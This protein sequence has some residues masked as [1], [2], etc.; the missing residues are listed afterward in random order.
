MTAR[1]SAIRAQQE[2]YRHR[3]SQICKQPTPALQKR[4][5]EVLGASLR[6]L[7]VTSATMDVHGHAAR[8]WLGMRLQLACGSPADAASALHP[9]SYLCSAPKLQLPG[10]AA[11]HRR[12]KLQQDCAR[13]PQRTKRSPAMPATD[14]PHTGQ[15]TCQGIPFRTC[16]L[17]TSPSP[18]DRTRSRMPSSA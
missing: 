12:A 16:L 17:Y 2:G 4:R 11:K 3:R 5:A 1:S 9:T 8:L 13:M 14:S 18:R 6:G 10:V 7:S 15:C